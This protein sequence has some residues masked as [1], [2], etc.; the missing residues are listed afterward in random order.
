MSAQKFDRII[1]GDFFPHYRGQSP[2]AYQRALGAHVERLHRRGVTHVMVNQALVN[3]PLA[4]QPD[5]PYYGFCAYGPGPDKYVTSSYNEGIFSE[6]LL[7]LNR[8]MLMHNVE[9]A[10]QYGFRCAMRCVEPIFQ[11]ETFFQ[12]YPHLRGPRIDNP[13]CSTDPVY[14]LCPMMPEA[15]DHY[16]QL[17]KN[18][19][20]LAPEIDELHIF[21]NDSG[22]GVCHSSHLYSGPNGPQHCRAVLPGKQAQVFCQT[23]VEGGR[24]VNPGFRAVM[25]S[26]LSPKEKADFVKEMPEG[27]ASS[28]Y[29]AF[30]WG[31]GLEDRWGTQAFGPEVYGN[32][33]VRATVHGWQYADHEARIRQIQDNGGIVYANYNSDYYSGDDPR[34]YE[35]HE[36]VCQL[37]EWG[38]TNVIGGAPGSTPYSANTAVFRHAVEHGHMP[39][40]Q[41]VQDIAE[42]WVG[43]ELAPALVEAWQLND[44]VA[45]EQPLP[46]AG[47]LLQIWALT[48]HMPIVPDE[49]QLQPGDLDYFRHALQSYDTKMSEQRGG[50]WRILHYGQELKAA[51]LRQFTTVVFPALEK[52]QAILDG[53]LARPG[54]TDAQRECLTAQRCA[55]HTVWVEHRHNYHWIAAACYRIAGETAPAGTPGLR[56]I[57][58]AEIALYEA[59]GRSADTDP[60]LRLMRAHRDDANVP[61]DMSEFALSVHAPIDE[62]E[63]AHLIEAA[64][65]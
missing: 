30:A 36:I 38:V 50:V 52:A 47:H 21:T 33:A 44:M 10:R 28:V 16:R 35:T 43:A 32:P 14:A 57:I 11:M 7:A 45:R 37:L 61:V 2:D 29:G 9:L 20:T 64:K 48:R 58:D 27:V 18:L 51:Y 63:G 53:L 39:T 13:A 8:E 49:A 59:E 23:L 12:R 42:Q 31:G 22:G 5:R 34:P 6:E 25:T 1:A 54:L 62:W 40:E 26:G 41:A 4:M 65:A 60:R 15:Q 19:L 46:Q 24:P 17:V 55:I 56:E 3:I